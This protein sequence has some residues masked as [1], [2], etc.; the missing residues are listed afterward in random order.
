MIRKT[1]FFW[2]WLFFLAK[3]SNLRLT[4][5]MALKIY[6]PVVKRLKLKTRELRR[7]IPTFVEV[8]KEKLLGMFFCPPPPPPTPTPFY[9]PPPPF[10]IGLRKKAFLVFSLF[11]K[12]EG[13]IYFWRRFVNSFSSVTSVIMRLRHLRQYQ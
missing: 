3:F 6:T 13:L 9:P 10:R 4:L 11:L 12:K 2:D 7:L 8:T 1:F 5:G